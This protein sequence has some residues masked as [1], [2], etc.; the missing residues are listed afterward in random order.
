MNKAAA[1]LIPGDVLHYDA[2]N[3]WRIDR[4]ISV[5]RNTDIVFTY[6]ATPVTSRVGKQGSQRMRS[7]T[8]RWVE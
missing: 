1:D 3:T 6:I 7:T 4:V 5:G 8:V 2:S